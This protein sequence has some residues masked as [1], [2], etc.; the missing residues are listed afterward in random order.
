MSGAGPILV[1]LAQATGL[2]M[3]ATFIVYVL[4]IAV[5]LARRRSAPAGDAATLGWHLF[6]PALNEEKVIGPTVD[7]L[8]RTLP[9]AHVWVIDDASE[10]RTG[11]IVAS[12]ARVDP[13]VHIVSRHFP[14]ARTGKGHALNAAYWQL[15]AGLPDGGRR[16]RLI[17][18]VIDADGRPAADCL[19]VCAGPG[20]FGDPVVDSVQIEVRMINRDDPR[21]FR[22][23]GRL[24]NFLAR[25]LIRMQDL[26][27]RVP[28]AAIQTTRHYTGTVGLGGNGQFTRMSALDT[29]AGADGGPWRGTLLEDYELSL[30]LTLSG[31]RTEFTRDTYVDQ[32]GLPDLR[33][34][35]R[36]RTRWG[37][38]TM[39]CGVYLRQ[40]WTSPHVSVLG[41]LEATY[42]LL[43]PWMQ[44]LG[45]IVYPLPIGIFVAHWLTQPFT[46]ES[47]LRSGGW[48]IMALYLIGG[49]GPFVLWG[50]IYRRKSERRT[51]LLRSI[52]LGFAY[53]L[54]VFIFYITSW[55]AFVRILRRRNEWFKTRRNAEFQSEPRWPGG[56]ELALPEPLTT[57]TGERW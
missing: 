8:R 39:Q 38:G 53:S 49:A 52:G 24:V 56:E 26:E 43:Q 9:E 42:Y 30:H 46:M 7:N 48:M 10:D 27:F 3:S 12:R 47:W 22:H 54:Y 11:A 21:P 4:I 32:E 28:I 34:F 25:I 41:A 23:R 51:G 50:P 17:I 13:M 20:L 16:D 37:Q 55:R 19:D 57:A 14:D 45:T 29:L 44:I 15:R 1:A 2:M 36:Q 6:V 33:R 35:I 5:P 31:H 40:L 18:G